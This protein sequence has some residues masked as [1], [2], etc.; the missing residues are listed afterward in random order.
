M[1][2]VIILVLLGK[3]NAL[4]QIKY[5]IIMVGSPEAQKARDTRAAT[6]RVIVKQKLHETDELI[7]K[8]QLN[9]LPSNNT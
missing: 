2:R 8:P 5:L 9:N 6:N 7:I 1:Y 3:E 4:M